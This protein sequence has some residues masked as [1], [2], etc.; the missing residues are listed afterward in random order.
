MIEVLCKLNSI[1][2]ATGGG[3]VL[4]KDNRQRLSDTGIVIYLTTS[5]NNQLKR[6]NHKGAIYRPLFIK[7]NSTEKIQ[8]LNEIRKPFYQLIADLT[9]KTDNLNPFQLAVQILS[10]VREMFRFYE[11]RT[12]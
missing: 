9:Y 6:I 1:I 7:N 3:A 11:N 5:I 4:N 12:N 10:D 8:Q 2:L